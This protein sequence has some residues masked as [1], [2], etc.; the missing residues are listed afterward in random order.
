VAIFFQEGD[1]VDLTIH[2]PST[3]SRPRRGSTVPD[4]VAAP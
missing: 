4:G 3:K 1:L 2:D